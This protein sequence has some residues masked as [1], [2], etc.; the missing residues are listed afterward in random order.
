MSSIPA[1]YG[2][3]D[4]MR[5]YHLPEELKNMAEKMNAS[6]LYLWKWRFNKVAILLEHKFHLAIICS[7]IMYKF[8]H[9]FGKLGFG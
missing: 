9:F 5:S 1:K 8:N 7:R 6:F 3:M 4:H 2:T